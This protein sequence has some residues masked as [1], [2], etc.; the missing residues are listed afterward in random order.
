MRLN[1]GVLVVMCALA[2]VLLAGCTTEN[3]VLAGQQPTPA[4]TISDTPLPVRSTPAPTVTQAGNTSRSSAQLVAFVEKAVA[5][6]RQNGKEKAL[7]AFS[8]PK[9]PFVDGELYIYAYDMNGT[10]L[11][12]PFNPEK[13]GVSRIAEKDASGGLF[14][15]NLRDTA[16]NGSGFVDFYYINPVNNRTVEKKLGYVMKVDDH[17]WLGS[18]IYFG[19]TVVKHATPVVTLAPSKEIDRAVTSVRENVTGQFELINRSL[20]ASAADLRNADLTGEKAR[21]SLST[22]LGSTPYAID[23]IT[24][25]PYGRVKA[26]EPSLYGD[27]VGGSLT[28]QEHIR[29]LFATGKPVTSGVIVTVEG[30]P[31]IDCAM[32]VY[33]P[34]GQVKGA[35][36]LLYNTSLWHDAITAADPTGVY[37]AFVMQPDGLIV[38]DADPV[39]TGRYVFSD[40]H[41]APYTSLLVLARHITAEP[42]GNGTYTY[43]D[44]NGRVVQKEATWK[45]VSLYGTEWR[46]VFSRTT[47]VPVP[48][49]YQGAGTSGEVAERILL[50]ALSNGTEQVAGM[51]EVLFRASTDMGVAGSNMTLQ[52]GILSRVCGELAPAIDCL[53]MDRSATIL[54]VRPDRYRNIVGRNLMYEGNIQQM[55]ATSRPVS[56]KVIPL[57]EG[58]NGIA[59]SYPVADNGNEN[60]PGAVSVSVDPVRFFGA[61]FASAAPGDGYHTWVMQPDGLM[62]YDNDPSQI[63]RKLFNDPLYAG[64][65]TLVDL[66]RQIAVK[67]S[68][69]GTFTLKEPGSDPVVKEACWGT[70]TVFGNEYRL[71]VSRVVQG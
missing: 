57:A 17:W 36:T 38:Y 26:V 2:T 49:A 22:L 48:A 28:D 37:E 29:R 39:Q 8:N 58:G 35:V 40:P 30:F 33:S 23:C 61:M 11:A 14:I 55:F 43:P 53:S 63:G 19:P 5:Y 46:V 52:G 45:T 18:G 66:G 50:A 21:E 51:D 20:S 62:V 16:A 7:E 15:R 56:S 34:E 24:V 42:S 71:V 10:T 41:Y 68:G 59:V 44:L 1:L 4:P 69:T 3:P 47:G 13:V 64:S 60:T 70:L 32:P 67:K 25:D 27:I 9:G 12:H 65:P 6:A 31:A 54:A